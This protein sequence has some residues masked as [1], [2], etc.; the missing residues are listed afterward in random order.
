MKVLLPAIVLLAATACNNNNEI[1]KE[2][3]VN[4][5]VSEEE[6]LKN[7]I[8]T[9][10]DSLQLRD[11]LINFYTAKDDYESAI[12]TVNQVL[13]KDSSIAYFWDLK[14]NLHGLNDDT[15]NAI[16]SLER[17]AALNP[18]P[19]YLLSLGYLYADTR[20]Q[21]AITIGDALIYADKAAAKKE[22]LLIKGIYYGKTG[23]EQKAIDLFDQALAIDYTFMFAYREK[24]LVQ[25]NQG[26][27]AEGIKT[28]QRGTT[29]QNSFDE[30]YYWMGRCY[31]KLG[32]TA[33]A[34][35]SYNKA[36]L[37][38]PGNDYVEA[39][40]ALSRLGVK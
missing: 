15:S 28:L 22:A 4:T 13:A 11:S 27:Y 6:Q 17:A 10:P 35:E 19:K 7:A 33:E 29:L 36:I 18:L 26:K 40:D 8:K 32:K 12:V 39:A 23:N 5:V 3:E 20:N 24:A 31:E 9:Y 38:A 34:I 1:E 2:K 21:K 16:R 37:Y 25:Y 14:A 30:G